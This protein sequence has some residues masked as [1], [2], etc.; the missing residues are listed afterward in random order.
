MGQRNA[1]RRTKKR[2]IPTDREAM[3]TTRTREPNDPLPL[4]GHV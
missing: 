3:A 4:D 1:I 2:V